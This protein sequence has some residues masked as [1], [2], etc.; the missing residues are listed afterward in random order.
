M[1]YDIVYNDLGEYVLI[2][3]REVAMTVGF[4]ID[5]VL[6]P[7]THI[8]CGHDHTDI[9]HC[10]QGMPYYP[11][12]TIVVNG[13]RQEREVS[14]YPQLKDKLLLSTLVLKD[15]PRIRQWIQYHAALG[16]DHFIIYDNAPAGDLS[17]RE[18]LEDEIRS[19]R[20][21]YIKWPHVYYLPRSGISGQTTQQNHSIRTFQ[22]AAYIGLTDV[23]E[24]MNPQGEIT[25][26]RA[27]LDTCVGSKRAELGGIEIV[28]KIFTNPTRVPVTGFRFFDA[29]HCTD[30]FLDARQKVFVI[31]PN[32]DMFSVHMIVSGKPKMTMD[33]SILYFNHYYFLNGK[34]REEIPVT[35]TDDSIRR[36]RVAGK[37]READA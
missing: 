23:D 6:H 15:E 9:Y 13:L 3:P 33:P 12:I 16:V 31:P 8:A 36:H 37:L 22:T 2:A 25:N 11:R 7:A 32:V 30:F 14:R 18:F 19:G 34:F 5:G 21:V 27:L 24:Y 35:H 10:S 29:V 1:I 26:L 17:L 20:V 4:F 28:S